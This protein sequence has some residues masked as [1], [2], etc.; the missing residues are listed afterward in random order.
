MTRSQLRSSTRSESVIIAPQG[1]VLGLVISIFFGW[2][3][4]RVLHGKGIDQFSLP[5]TSLI[6]VVLLVGLAGVMAAILPSRRAAKLDVLRPS[7]PS[8][9]TTCN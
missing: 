5:V 6:G 3:L 2:A 1:T 9:E 4:V 8:R 7:P